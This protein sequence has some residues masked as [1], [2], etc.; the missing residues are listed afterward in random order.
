MGKGYTE[1]REERKT[2]LM[3]KSS[4]EQIISLTASLSK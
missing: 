3:V 2:E 4:K 1:A